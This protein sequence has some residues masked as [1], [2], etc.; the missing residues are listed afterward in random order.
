M[1]LSGKK[2]TTAILAGLM[3][4]T[5][6][7]SSVFAD[8]ALENVQTLAKQNSDKIAKLTDRV[9]DLETAS[10]KD[11]YSKDE[12]DSKLADKA[13]QSAVNTNTDNISKNTSAIDKEATA[14]DAADKTL[15]SNIDKEA[16]AR[17]D[18]DAIEAKA[19]QDA[20]TAEA[21]ARDAADKTLQ[22]NIDKEAT[23][24]QDADTAEAKARQAADSQ[25]NTNMTNGFAAIQG[26]Q[27]EQDAKIKHNEDGITA[28]AGNIKKALSQQMVDF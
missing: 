27:D 10:S 14:R 28:N 21:T 22:G 17:Q 26:Q 5:M 12:V 4:A 6:F 8:S 23:A 20:D 19:R 25:L 11:T 24:R 2:L 15:Q 9:S 13:N 18:A 1:Q 16:T 7:G 3:G